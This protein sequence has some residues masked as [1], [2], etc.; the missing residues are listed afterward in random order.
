[1]HKG[2]V[3]AGRAIETLE[4]VNQYSV[5]YDEDSMT[6]LMNLVLMK[7]NAQNSSNRL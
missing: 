5:N 7:S 6:T 4:L 1:M 2:T 3:G